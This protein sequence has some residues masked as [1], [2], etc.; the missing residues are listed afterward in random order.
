[1]TLDE[2]QFSIAPNEQAVLRITSPSG[3]WSGAT[4]NWTS[5]DPDENIGLIQLKVSD[6]QVGSPHPDFELPLVDGEGL[7]ATARLSDYQGKVLFLAWW[8]DF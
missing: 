7:T 3:N 5:N 6:S 4:L 1:M 8:A 2:N